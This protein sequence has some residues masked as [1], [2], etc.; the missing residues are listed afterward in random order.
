MVS[1]DSKHILYQHHCSKKDINSFL[2]KPFGNFASYATMP[3]SSSSSEN[4][5]QNPASII[6]RSLNSY[7][8]FANLPNQWYR[9]SIKKGFRLNV[10][11]V[12][13]S[14]LGKSTLISTLFNMPLYPASIPRDPGTNLPKTVSIESV[15]AD[16]DENGVRLHLTVI[17][18]PGFGDFV[19]NTDSW[20]PIIS[21]IEQR[22]DDYLEAENF[23]NRTVI[24]DNRIHAC[25]YFIQPTGHSLKELDVVFMKKLHKKVNLIPIISKADTFTE[26][27]IDSFKKSIM[28]DIV[29][30]GIDIFKPPKYANDD[31]NTTKENA[32]LM[33]HVPFAVVGSME[34]VESPNFK[35]PVRGRQ[36][37][38]G[39]IEVENEEHNDFVKLRRILVCTHLEELCDK[40]ANILYENYRRDKL[41]ELGIV[42][43]STVF[44]E[45]N[46][47]LRQEEER[48]AQD[49]R[50]AKVEADLK[51]SF[52]MKVAEKENKLKHSE[53]ELFTRH[54][55]LSENIMKTINEL[56]EK[57]AR[58]QAEINQENQEDNIVSSNNR[59]SHGHNHGLEEKKPRRG[60]SLR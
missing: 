37:P 29:N 57:R 46:P 15:T 49:A 53:A 48:V 3:T 11:V 20:E 25:L 38:W 7:V 6:H 52:Q 26:E 44:R 10:M 51:T 54:R 31:K 24:D 39:I 56:N 28:T 9:K 41:I 55:E 50:L 13:E 27:E 43:D 40:T 14:G 12:G 23:V 42:Q 2:P 34:S 59:Q 1:V 58:L 45:V 18:T 60:F 5:I 21:D 47:A 32:E 36:Y 30:Q 4:A 35:M 17:D 16:L 33:L 19:N 8:G 22:F